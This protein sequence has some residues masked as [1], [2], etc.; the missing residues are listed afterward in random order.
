MCVT[1][2]LACLDLVHDGIELTEQAV[3]ARASTARLIFESHAAEAYSV[4]RRLGN[5]IHE[6]L[7]TGLLDILLRGSLD[8][9]VVAWLCRGG[10]L[11]LAF[12]Q[13]D[14]SKSRMIIVVS[15]TVGCAINIYVICG[16]SW[17]PG[18]DT[19]WTAFLTVH[20]SH[21]MPMRPRCARY[22]GEHGGTLFLEDMFAFGIDYVALPTYTWQSIVHPPR[23]MFA[24]ACLVVQGYYSSDITLSNLP[25]DD[26]DI[27][28]LV[29]C[30]VD[31]EDSG[32][33]LDTTLDQFSGGRSDTAIAARTM[34][35]AMMAAIESSR[36]NTDF[37]ANVE[38]RHTSVPFGPDRA[39]AG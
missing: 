10:D 2:A 7:L 9:R 27:P 22:A 30:G 11:S 14:W 8:A 16:D 33:S 5:P 35:I 4:I 39:S 1:I 23:C 15:P 12:S 20:E 26:D 6:S 18:D 3:S 34:C 36:I 25:S 38:R 13:R 19:S 32:A 29:W 37:Q 24:D 31:D 21:A 28:E 17:N